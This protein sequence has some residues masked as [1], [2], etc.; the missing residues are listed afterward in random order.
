[1][2]VLVLLL[3]GCVWGV[4][5]AACHSKANKQ[6]RLA[7][8]KFALFQMLATGALEGEGVGSGRVGGW[9]GWVWGA[10]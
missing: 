6:A 4:R 8:T 9:G 7:E 1:M 3:K 5:G 2:K 10:G